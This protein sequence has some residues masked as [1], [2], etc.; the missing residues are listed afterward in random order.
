MNPPP[1]GLTIQRLCVHLLHYAT[2]EGSGFVPE[3]SEFMPEGGGFMPDGSGFM[4]YLLIHH[5]VC[6]HPRE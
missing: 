6:S 1:L 2:T 3:G 5:D 4:F